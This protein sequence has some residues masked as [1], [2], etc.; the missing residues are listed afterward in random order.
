MCSRERNE[1]TEVSIDVF[2][3]LICDIISLRFRLVKMSLMAKVWWRLKAEMLT[4]DL[5]AFRNY[6]E[7]RLK[8]RLI[9]GLGYAFR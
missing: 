1:K 8:Q 2:F 4:K 6:A 9:D 3:D 7:C 5:A